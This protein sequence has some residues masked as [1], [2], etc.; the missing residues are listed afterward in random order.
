MVFI[1]GGLMQLA[2]K[3]KQLRIKCGYTQDELAG[4]L[5]VSSQAISKWENQITT[6]DI[7][8]LPLLSEVFGVTIDELFDLSIEQKLERIENK[9]DVE[10]ELTVREFEDIESFLKSQLNQKENARKINYLLAYLYTHRFMSD[11]KKISKYGREAIRLDPGLRENTQWMINK[12][13]AGSCWDWDISNHTGL[14]KFYKEVVKEN[15]EVID[16]YHHLI[17]NLIDDNRLDEATEYVNKLKELYSKQKEVHPNNII[18]V[19]AYRA[20]IELRR[21]NKKEAD[22]IM[23]DLSNEY[24][25]CDGYFFELAQYY[26]KSGRY[27][28]AVQLYE[29]SFSKD[30]RRPRYSDALLGIIDIY[31]IMGNTDKEIETYDSLLKLYKE[32]WKMSDDEATYLDA[33]EKKNKLL[34]KNK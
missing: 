1:G 18:V 32:E 21:H 6:P 10:E 12:A 9:L 20:E 16:P 22:K 5:G 23:E 11:S 31:D 7:T 24:G 13:E 15:P 19:E 25:E 2:N 14:I 27:E 8:V 33:L 3:I 29:D 30:K 4:R 28:E 26:T 17:W 34:N